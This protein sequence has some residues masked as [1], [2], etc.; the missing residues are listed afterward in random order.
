MTDGQVFLL[1]GRRRSHHVFCKAH[2]NAAPLRTPNHV[3][4]PSRDVNTYA[5]LASSAGTS[6]AV[7]SFHSTD[8]G[9]VIV[10]IVLSCVTSSTKK[11][12]FP[13]I[14]PNPDTSKVKV[15][16]PVKVPWWYW[17]AAISS[18]GVVP[19]NAARSPTAAQT[20]R[21]PCRPRRRQQP[22]K[23]R[24][25]CSTQDQLAMPRPQP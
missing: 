22:A 11:I 16:F 1:G 20:W 24:Q 15:V 21:V 6:G 19:V 8:A 17:S 13:L 25:C 9:K 14:V 2:E 4:P 5:A 18:D 3:V 12:A 7:P 23:D 10:R